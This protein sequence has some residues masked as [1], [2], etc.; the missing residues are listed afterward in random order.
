[1]H[2]V[3][4]SV[5]ILYIVWGSAYF[6]LTVAYCKY[7]SCN[8]ATIDYHCMGTMPSYWLTLTIDYVVIEV[9]SK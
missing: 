6:Q 2:E 8:M 3:Y 1:M 9:I 4:F 7:N 5:I